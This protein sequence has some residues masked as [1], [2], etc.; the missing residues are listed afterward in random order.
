MEPVEKLC[1]DGNV[2]KLNPDIFGAV[3]LDDSTSDAA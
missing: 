2:G 3:L 1:I